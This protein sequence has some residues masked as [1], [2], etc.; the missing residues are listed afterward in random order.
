[1]ALVR[2][3][4]QDAIPSITWHQLLC[5]FRIGKD[6]AAERQAKR[7]CKGKEGAKERV[8]WKQGEGLQRWWLLL[9]STSKQSLISQY[10]KHFQPFPSWAPVSCYLWCSSTQPQDPRRSL[11]TECE[12][13]DKKN[14]GRCL[15]QS[16]IQRNT[17]LLATDWNVLIETAITVH[18]APLCVCLLLLFTFLYCSYLLSI[19]KT[20]FVFLSINWPQ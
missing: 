20:I 18:Y 5:I 9:I 17:F 7:K 13:C 4:L 3:S 11:W 14:W 10:L 1:M 16:I 8:R 6:A 19:G 15:L 12:L 2:L